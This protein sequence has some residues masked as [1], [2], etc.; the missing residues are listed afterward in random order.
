MVQVPLTS[1]PATPAGLAQPSPIASAPLEPLFLPFKILKDHRERAA[2][3]H[4]E[5]LIGGSADKYRPL[6]AKQEFCHL[7]TADYTI[8][9][10]PVF[11]ERKAE[12]DFLSSI[13]H[14]HVNFRKEHERMAEIIAA[15]GHCCVIIEADYGRILDDLESGTSTRNIHPA[16]VKGAVARMTAEFNIPW[17]FAGS[18][19]RAEEQAFLILRAEWERR[20][21]KA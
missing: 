13:T 11:I 8:E 2:G 5:G 16:S 17:H 21:V 10:C 3:W 12:G 20:Q 9:G 1:S 7:V 18:R 15:G 4:F 14:G 6:V 19:R